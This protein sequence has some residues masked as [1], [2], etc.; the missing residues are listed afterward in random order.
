[1]KH[2]SDIYF[3]GTPILGNLQVDHERV[4]CGTPQKVASYYNSDGRC[5]KRI[6]HVSMFS[7]FRGLLS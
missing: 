3:W 5:W 6:Y 7:K 4:F 2:R 1:M